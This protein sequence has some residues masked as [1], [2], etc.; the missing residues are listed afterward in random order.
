MKG[1]IELDSEEVV[2]VFERSP[3]YVEVVEKVRI[4]L[5]WMNP[6]DEI[7]LEG[8]FNVSFGMH[9]HWKTMKLNSEKKWSTYKEAVAESQEKAL[10]LFATKKVSS[11]PHLD[12]N[13]RA[14]P[15]VHGRSPF[16]RDQF[17][18]SDMWTTQQVVLL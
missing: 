2:M 7:E 8:M 17:V 12:L 9:N 10:E 14:S 6:S 11:R 13:R 1:N 16:G 4:E 5:E 15:S 18:E 3:N